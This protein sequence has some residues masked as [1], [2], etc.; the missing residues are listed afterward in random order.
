MEPSLSNQGV[1]DYTRPY[2]SHPQRTL[3]RAL[4]PIRLAASIQQ[5]MS[6]FLLPPGD[7]LME[8]HKIPIGL[9]MSRLSPSG[10]G[11]EIGP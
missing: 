6:S 9:I 8:L 4:F 7:L 5:V 3:I 11:C 1:S 10:N 2:A